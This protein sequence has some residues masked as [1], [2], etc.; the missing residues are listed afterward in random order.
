MRVT[1][2]VV[3]FRKLCTISTTPS[4]TFRS[5]WSPKSS[6]RCVHQRSLDLQDRT[7][8]CFSSSR[9]DDG[10]FHFLVLSGQTDLSNVSSG[11]ES[12][13]TIESRLTPV[14]RPRQTNEAIQ[15]F[16]RFDTEQIRLD[17]PEGTSS[18]VP[19]LDIFADVSGYAVKEGMVVL[20]G[21]GDARRLAR[22]AFAVQSV[23]RVT[24]RTYPMH[25]A[26]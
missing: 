16:S 13:S 19:T 15:Y 20:R 21:R 10:H 23:H 9:W 22:R 3:D 11:A 26:C 25:E 4:R 1:C 17:G 14:S 6:P 12:V 7:I 8:L 24:R 2:R 5:S 18:A